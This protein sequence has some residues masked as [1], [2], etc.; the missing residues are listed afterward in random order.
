MALAS[1]V[2]I[3]ACAGDVGEP[4][5][6]V[7]S[8]LSWSP[9]PSGASTG[10]DFWV[11]PHPLP[12]GEPGDVIRVRSIETPAGEA[13]LALHLSSDVRGD[14]VAVSSV[15]YLPDEVNASTP[16]LA[17]AHGTTGIADECAPSRLALGG[18]G[19]DLDLAPDLL[20]QGRVVVVTDYQGLG[21]PGR[22]P[23]LVT[24]AAAQNVLDSVRAIERLELTDG[25]S[26]VVVF[27]FSQGGGAAAYVADIAGTTRRSSTCGASSQRHRRRS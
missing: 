10:D 25:S 20:D 18:I 2:S 4:D 12:A 6:P 26:P 21:T 3:T 19:G 16:V 24:R 7:A 1:V 11:P 13:T 14:P 15:V 5:E 17:V 22:H 27:G 9:S 23:Y 8:V